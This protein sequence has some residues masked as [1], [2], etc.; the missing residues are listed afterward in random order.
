MIRNKHRLFFIILFFICVF[1]YILSASQCSIEW[2]EKKGVH[3]IIRYASDIPYAWISRLLRYAENY[4]NKIASQIGYTRYTDFWTW[5]KRTEIIV[6]PDRRAFSEATGQPIWSRGGAI[7]DGIFR[8]G[9]LIVTFWQED[10]FLEGVLPHEIS[11][12]ILHDYIGSSQIIPVWLDEGLAQFQ[13]KDKVAVADMVV[14]NAIK[15][16]DG[17]IPFAEFIKADF[18]YSGMDKEKIRLFYAQSLSVVAFLIH[19]YGSNSFG[20]LCHYLRD[21]MDFSIA[22]KK[23]YPVIFK[24]IFMLERKWIKYI[25]E[26]R[27]R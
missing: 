26:E 20:R 22:L 7:R 6:Y 27:C 19:R 5:D 13:E 8:N 18:R 10:G 15:N 16:G 21:G 2:K 14:C 12:L 1:P 24:D 17:Y 23:A 3:F 9:R 11:H 4:Y 25:T